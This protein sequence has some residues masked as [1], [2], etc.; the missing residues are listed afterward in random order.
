MYIIKAGEVQVLGGPEGQTVLVSLKA[1]SVFGEI[2]LLAVGGG[3]R[4]T[5]N[6]VAHGF[7]NL[8]ILD[9]KDLSD[10]LTHYPES[11][12]VLRRKAK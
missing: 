7:T 10:I 1:G 8:F 5:A 3:N 11:Q 4:R 6:V 2:S 12:K 9:K